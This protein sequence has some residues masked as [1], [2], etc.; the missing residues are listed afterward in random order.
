MLVLLTGLLSG[1]LPAAH[2]ENIVVTSNEDA[3]PGTL[4]DALERAAA[5][6][7]DEVDIISFN[8]PGGTLEARTILLDSQLPNIPSHVVIDGTAQPGDPFGDSDAKVRVMPHVGVYTNNNPGAFSILNATDIEIYGLHITGF[9]ALYDEH[10]S[11]PSFFAIQVRGGS[12]ITIGKPGAGNVFDNNSVHINVLPIQT[13]IP[14]GI[15]LQS[16]KIGIGIND[17]INRGSSETLALRI[18]ASDVTFGGTSEDQGNRVAAGA[19]FQLDGFRVE[20][21]EFESGAQ[22]AS[23]ENGE[24]RDNELKNQF[25]QLD[26]SYRDIG[27]YGNQNI[28][29]LDVETNV[30]PDQVFIKIGTDDEADINT[31]TYGGVGIIGFA[32]VRRNSFNCV[33]YPF[34]TEAEYPSIEVLENS[35]GVFRGTATP[36]AEIYIYSDDTDCDITSPVKFY[37]KI[38]ADADGNWEITGDFSDQRF[39]ANAVI[40]NQSSGYTQVGFKDKYSEH[41]NNF[42]LTNP[43]CGED[44]GAIEVI[45]YLHTL[46]IDWYDVDGTHIGSGDRI[47]NLEPGR[48]TCILRNGNGSMSFTYEL[49]E[50]EWV[51]YWRDIRVVHSECGAPVGRIENLRVV[52]VYHDEFMRVQWF[53]EWNNVVDTVGTLRNV[54]PGTYFLRAYYAEDCYEEY[55]V[56]VEGPRADLSAMEAQ[57]ITCDGPG[58][59]TG[60]NLDGMAYTEAFWLDDQG[61]KLAD[62]P[63]LMDIDR[64]GTYRLALVGENDCDT[65]WAAFVDI[66]ETGIPQFDEQSLQIIPVSCDGTTMGSIVGLMV[67]SAISFEWQ[68][69]AGQVVGNALELDNVPAGRYRLYVTTDEECTAYSNWYQVVQQEVVFPEYAVSMEQ[70]SCAGNDG[71]LA[72]DWGN[73]TLRPDTWRWMDSEGNEVGT[74]MRAEGLTPGVYHLMLIN[75]N[76]C[77]FLDPREFRLE[78]AVPL[79]LDITAIRVQDVVRESNT[80]AISGIE[81]VGGTAPYTYSWYDDTGALVGNAAELSGMPAGI[82]MLEVVDARGC[83]SITDPITVDTFNG[84]DLGI[85]NTFTPNGDGYND[86]WFPTGL[87]RYTR[88]LVRIFDRQGQLVYEGRST[89]APFSGQY[90]STDLPVGAYYFV[91]DLGIEYP[92]LKGSLNL[93]R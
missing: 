29:W 49:H 19:R 68:D 1:W 9:H 57:H 66:R 56:P 84:D 62:G 31:F 55:A 33:Y 69:E 12:S 75:E 53:D 42:I 79:A 39:T 51:F 86:T 14:I 18:N 93:L 11:N 43:Y 28:S 50:R 74:G 27:I 6:G 60:V 70:P 63:D 16:N 32:E 47:E 87:E 73:N 8:L 35:H 10:F 88:A 65:V 82:Y 90:R 15:T 34:W 85:P 17:E 30:P 24:I 80:G 2:A 91:I 71:V 13:N 64:A 23:S 61:V 92:S 37:Q 40:D 22:F 36:N 7:E 77:E 54:P 76:G 44:N 21:N 78:E 58:E 81:V 41:R 4:R 67:E 20:N 48:Y 72:I 83:R 5:N 89:D 3:G 45:N 26:N 59:I 38:T 46:Q 52:P 25:L